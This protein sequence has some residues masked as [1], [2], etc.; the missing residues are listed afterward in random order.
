MPTLMLLVSW[1][2]IPFLLI[3][4][5]L[6]FSVFVS[7]SKPIDIEWVT[8]RNYFGD[9]FF[10]YIIYFGILLAYM[11]TQTEIKHFIMIFVSLKLCIVIFN[12][13]KTL[14]L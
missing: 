9:D 13:A 1:K 11:Y 8:F 4:L 7:F 6:S 3:D 12:W 5:F 14:K 2:F 10:Q